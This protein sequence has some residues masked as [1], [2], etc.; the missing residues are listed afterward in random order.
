MVRL[1]ASVSIAPDQEP[2]AYGAT[3]ISVYDAAGREKRGEVRGREL[4]LLDIVMFI[5]LDD[6]ERVSNA[7]EEIRLLA[8][9]DGTMHELRER[10][11]QMVYDDGDRWPRWRNLMAALKTREVHAD[12]PAIAALPLILEF[13]DEVLALYKPEA[14]Y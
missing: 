13:T 8:R 6:G 7:P 3:L 12:D 5:E 4:E 11:E 10:V 9:L 1:G 2:E 14:S